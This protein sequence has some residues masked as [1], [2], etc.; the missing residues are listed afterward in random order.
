MKKKLTKLLTFILAIV[1]VMSVIQIPTLAVAEK[2]KAQIKVSVSSA[3]PQKGDT[4]LVTVELGNY[5]TMTPKVSAMEL[6][7]KFDTSVFELVAD[8][9]ERNTLTVNNGDILRIEASGEDQI[10][11]NYCYAN[12]KGTYLPRENISRFI[13]FRFK[14]KVRED[15]ARDKKAEF[16]ITKCNIYDSHTRN[17]TNEVTCKTPITQDVKAYVVRP[18]ILFNESGTNEAVYDKMVKVEFNNTATAQVTYE[19]G[20]PVAVLN[21][22]Y[23]KENGTYV[24]VF[25]VN[26]AEV[27]HQFTVNREIKSISLKTGSYVKEYA[28]NENLNLSKGELIVQYMDESPYEEE[29]GISYIPL[30]DSHISVSGYDKAMPGEQAL[31]V[32][33]MNNYNTTMMVNV[34]NVSIHTAVI[35]PGSVLTYPKTPVGYAVDPAGIVVTVMYSDGTQEDRTVDSSML[36][37]YMKDV[38]GTVN[39]EV[40]IADEVIGTF[41]A[42]YVS[43]EN[44]NAFKN[45]VNGIDPYALTVKDASTVADLKSRYST[46]SSQF[47]PMVFADIT[48]KYN[49]IVQR[50]SEIS[51]GIETTPSTT[52]VDTAPSTQSGDKNDDKNNGASTFK[53]VGW[54]IAVIILVSVLAGCTYFIVVYIK[55][56]KED[57]DYYYD[58][59]DDD[60]DDMQQP[61]VAAFDYDDDDFISND[62]SK[63]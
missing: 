53:I 36:G 52:P 17:T 33:Y 6:S 59:D 48:S 25:N 16:E 29:N 37:E 32:T 47:S 58:D 26:G 24:M 35:K 8:S 21:P 39:V 40:K 9:I 49:S 62:D 41:T 56:K 1:T 45:E 44:L 15:L 28:L 55:R 46:L 27:T 10:D 5:A 3:S 18:D 31:I 11:M 43:N 30:T 23:A 4:I 19:G 2:D 61:T 60:D 54:I 38:I 57:E 7:V 12:D 42:E 22:F 50:M 20:E 14:L 51:G 63:K 13:L 34:K